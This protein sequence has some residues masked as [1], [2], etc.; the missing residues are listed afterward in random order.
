MIDLHSH[1]LPGID[2][3]SRDA[4]MSQQML[5]L[6][7]QQGVDTVV[8]TPHFYAHQD[9]P[10]AFLTRRAEA[11]AKLEDVC[12]PKILLGAE[13]AYFDGIGRCQDMTA[14]RLGDSEL[15]L[16]EMP[17]SSWTGRMV[18]E[19]CDMPLQL[20]VTPVLAHVDR[21]RKEIDRYGDILLSSG[22]LFQCNVAAI[23]P[24]WTRRWALD[25]YA[26]GNIHFLGTDARNLTTRP[27]EMGK[28][29]RILTEKFGAQYL[30]DR[31]AFSRQML[32][33]T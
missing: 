22:A 18:E 11:F 27:P 33:I 20:G 15:L 7:Q 24:R 8:A 25:L 10:D 4:Q 1:I 29:V 13:V 16:V 2:D 28:G 31:D 30:E 6:L 5:A 32:N 26:R 12:Q 3:G 17:W 23:L 21:Y 14:L 19:I 9:A